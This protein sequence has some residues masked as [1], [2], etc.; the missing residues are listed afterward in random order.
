MR[1]CDADES[2]RRARPTGEAERMKRTSGAVDDGQDRRR[3]GARDG[4]SPG[5]RARRL[6]RVLAG[7]GRTRTSVCWPA[8]SRIGVIATDDVDAL[9]ALAPDCVSYMPFRPD[10]D[11]V[12]RILESGINLVTH[13]VHARGERLRRRRARA[14]RRRCRTRPVVAVRERH[15]PRSRQHGGARRERDVHAHRLH[16][17]ARV[18][19]HER[20]RERADVPGD[21]HRPRARRPGS[22]RARRRRVRIVQGADQGDGAARSSWRSPRSASRPSSAPPIAPPTS[23]S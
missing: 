22:A 12:V 21:G 14:D 18:A 9:L 17:G 19:R 8:S 4:R 15:L 23:A 1:W 13:D 11:H 20:V 2:A 16:L 7:E 6:L 3:R 10:F 5:A